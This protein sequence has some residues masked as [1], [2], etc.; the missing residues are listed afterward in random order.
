V[1][2]FQILFSG[3]VLDGATEAAV[4]T[5]LAR[6]LAIDERKANRLFSG[7]T[8]VLKSDLTRD[9][10]EALQR[11]LGEL[12]AVVRIKDL[13][14]DDRATF[15]VDEKLRDRT[16]KDITAAHLECPR[17]GHLQLDAEHCARCGV[18]IEAARREKRREDLLIEQKIRELR[19]RKARS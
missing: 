7:R 4:R 14:P 9:A 11:E 3:Q 12:G 18:E 17:C 13:S 15:K 1:D 6:K 8:V 16:L 19:G 10:A 5:N 2:R